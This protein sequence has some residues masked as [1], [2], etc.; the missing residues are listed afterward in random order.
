MLPVALAVM[1]ADLISKNIVDKKLGFNQE[2]PVIKETL[3][4]K[5][6]YNRGAAFGL[7]SDN[8]VL[9]G[10]LSGLAF[11]NVLTVF[12]RTIEKDSNRVQRFAAAFVLGGAMGNMVSRLKPGYV[13]DFLCVKL[14][15]NAPVFNVADIFITLGTIILLKKQKNK[16]QNAGPIF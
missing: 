2:I 14:K 8:P 3:C 13:V 12:K 10:I 1:T 11:L 15:K 9:L 16:T 7:F 4:L 5:K 6:V